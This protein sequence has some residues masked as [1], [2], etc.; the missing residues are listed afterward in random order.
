MNIRARIAVIAMA[1]TCVMSLCSCDNESSSKPDK[2]DT[3]TT[4]STKQPAV[5]FPDSDSSEEETFVT[6]NDFNEPQDTTTTTT[7][8]TTASESETVITTTEE[9]SGQI[10]TLPTQDSSATTTTTTE[11][12]SS[13]SSQGEGSEN[14]DD[15]DPGVITLPFV[16]AN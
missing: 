15:S 11:S 1:A 14:K 2:G 12:S 5:K 8:T 6:S 16:P 9:D 13:D 7:T 10:V 3:I 4:T